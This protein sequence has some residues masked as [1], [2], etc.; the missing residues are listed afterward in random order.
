MSGW[1]LPL[2]YRPSLAAQHPPAKE[3]KRTNDVKFG[4][5][6]TVI[7]EITADIILQQVEYMSNQK[8]S[9]PSSPKVFHSSVVVQDVH[10]LVGRGGVVWAFKLFHA[11]LS[12]A[13][14]VL[15]SGAEPVGSPPGRWI[16]TAHSQT[17]GMRSSAR[18]IHDALSAFQHGIVIDADRAKFQHA[19]AFWRDPD[20]LKT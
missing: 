20:S 14:A 12:P 10:R 8:P 5:A 16:V 19:V 7:T 17:S 3:D 1:L 11:A 6:L 4:I 13:L 2:S 18:R 15:K 9:P